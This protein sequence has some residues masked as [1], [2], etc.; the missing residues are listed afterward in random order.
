MLQ[1]YEQSP[2]SPQ[3][4]DNRVHSDHVTDA[5]HVTKLH[6]I[7]HSLPFLSVLEL[8]TAGTAAWEREAALGHSLL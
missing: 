8:H 1:V 3:G 7:T 2:Q 6:A 4:K 5:D